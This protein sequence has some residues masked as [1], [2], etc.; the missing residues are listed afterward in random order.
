M[1]WELKR[2]R[3]TSA[4]ACVVMLMPWVT[5][6]LAVVP[7]A[8]IFAQHLPGSLCL[9]LFFHLFHLGVLRGLPLTHDRGA[10]VCVRV[11]VLLISPGFHY[12]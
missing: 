2:R 8:G 1:G 10:I 12:L 6:P 5:S 11:S 9:F 7:Q 3:P 4:Q